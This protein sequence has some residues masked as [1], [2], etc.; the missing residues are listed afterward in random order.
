MPVIAFS[1]MSDFLADKL[2]RL[3]H[4]RP[5]VLD[6]FSG[7]GGI[8]LGFQRAGCE[9]LG[10]VEQA[11]LAARTHAA[12]FHP[13]SEDDE[14]SLHGTSLDI[15]AVDPLELIRDFGHDRPGA[16]VDLIVGGPPCQAYARVGRAKLR[17]V[18]EHP[19]AFKVDERGSLFEHYLRY[20]A[21]LRPVALLMENV[22][23]ILN[24]GG[25]NVAE[26]ITDG[27]QG[28]GYSCRYTL[29][30]AAAYGVPQTRERFYLLAWDQRITSS[31]PTFPQPTHHLDDLPVG[32]RGTR[33]VA[34]KLA[35]AAQ[36]P[37]V[38]AELQN[39]YDPCSYF[40][41]AGLAVPL[42][43]ADAIGDLPAITGHLTGQIKRGARRFKKTLPYSAPPHT[44]YTRL[45]REGWEPFTN[46]VGVADHVIRYLPR[47]FPIFRAMDPG[48]QYPE[49]HAKALGLRDARREQL[50][51]EKGRVLSDQELEELTARMVPPYDVNKFPNKWRKLEA[52]APSRTLMAHLGHDSYS[53][54]HYASDQA[55]TISVREAAR[56]Q[57]FPDGFVFRGTMN[58]AFRMIGNAVPP[59]MSFALARH[60]LAE[61][62]AHLIEER[63]ETAAGGG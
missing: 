48:D 7:C 34:R 17:E 22:P 55:R 28:L 38:G 46:D 36:L 45:M 14:E 11:E 40:E 60:I 54:I 12:N 20:V 43:A 18:Q 2:G 30:N 33:A 25:E 42:G 16:A 47:D 10:G 5:T 62:R 51:R 6:L 1:P 59:L 8:S 53:H 49:A 31:P 52:D 61:L 15:R 41:W 50:E 3:E 57:S 21:A 44:D 26:V 29:L 27:L 23:D 35:A 63:T 9:I 32:Y 24:Y 19:E 56:L 37:L 39:H 4:G 13:E 58:P